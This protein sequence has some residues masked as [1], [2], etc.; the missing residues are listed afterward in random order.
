MELTWA[1]A[2]LSGE[3]LSPNPSPTATGALLTTEASGP[4]VLLTLASELNVPSEKPGM[5]WN[6]RATWGSNEGVDVQSREDR[7]Q[8][9][10][11]PAC[12]G[13]ARATGAPAFFWTLGDP[14]WYRNSGGRTTRAGCSPV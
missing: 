8:V 1:A 5:A 11:P 9:S 6:C 14:G 12:D 7:F 3:L 10:V 2:A 4:L 13:S